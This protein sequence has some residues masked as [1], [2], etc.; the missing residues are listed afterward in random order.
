MRTRHSGRAARRGLLVTALLC[1]GLST[2]AAA[3]SSLDETELAA[4]HGAGVAL[5][6]D[7]FQFAMAPT[8]YFEQV[9]SAPSNACTS[10]GNTAGNFNC[11]RRGDLRWYGINIS[12]AGNTGYHWNDSTSCTANSLNCPRGGTIAHFSPFDNPYLIRA[13]SPAGMSYGGCF[14]NGSIAGYSAAGGCTAPVAGQKAIYEFLAPTSQPNYTFSWWG[15]IESGSTRNSS[16]QALATGAGNILKSQNIIRGNAAGSVFRL[17]TFTEAGNE[18]FGIFYHSRLQG[19]YRL[20]VAQAGTGSNAIGQP[21]VFADTEGL[22]FR[23]VNAFVPLGQLYYQA[24]TLKAVGTGGNFE[25]SLPPLPNTAAVYNLHYALNGG[26]TQGYETARANNTG[27]ATSAQYQL[28]HGFSRWGGWTASGAWTGRNLINGNDGTATGDGVIFQ[29]CSGCTTFRAYAERPHVIDK[30]GSHFSMAQMQNYNCATANAG[31]CSTGEGPITTGDFAGTQASGCTYMGS[32]NHNCYTANGLPG[33]TPT[34]AG[35]RTKT[36][37]TSVVN[38]GD[39]RIEGLMFQSLRFE[40]CG[41][42]ATC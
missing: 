10:V 5:G 22:H 17:F 30:R 13:W 6:F 37:T 25:L 33:G 9:G 39:A 4:V 16:S 27:G 26:D 3:L 15:E 42:S 14:L 40:S 35:D 32:T 19:D 8:S 31:G 23:N 36:Y 24:L 38:L 41:G 18:T 21:V 12:G 20:S 29:A 28:T 34:P 1:L 11:W 7:D 2:P